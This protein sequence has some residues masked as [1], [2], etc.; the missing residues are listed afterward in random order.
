VIT[1]EDIN[2]VVAGALNAQSALAGKAWPGRGPDEP[3]AYPY[4]VFTVRAGDAQTFSGTRYVQKWRVRAAAYIPI[5]APS[6]LTVADVLAALAV[7]LGIT[8]A[9]VVTDLR[10]TGEKVLGTR[11][12][13]AEEWY[14]PSLR[15]GKDVLAAGLSVELLCQGDRSVS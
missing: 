4:A 15:A 8:S 1:T 12:V 11:P 7:A 5:G 9:A 2:T 14:A 13:T 10:N 3:G 6:A